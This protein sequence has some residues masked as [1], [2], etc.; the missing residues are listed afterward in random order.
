MALFLYPERGD[1]VFRALR[2][3]GSAA[4]DVAASQRGDSLSEENPPFGTPR[5]RRGDTPRPRTLRD[6]GLNDLFACGMHCGVHGF[7]MNPCDS[8]PGSTAPYSVGRE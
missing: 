4:R 1:W 3:V 5:E 8:L 7:A 2:G 6:W